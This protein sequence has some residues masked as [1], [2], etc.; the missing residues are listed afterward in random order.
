M[1]SESRPTIAVVIHP[2]IHDRTSPQLIRLTSAFAAAD[3]TYETLRATALVRRDPVILHVNWPEHVVRSDGPLV[4]RLLKQAEAI[5]IAMLLVVRPHAVVWTAHNLEPHDGWNGPIE[6]S[7]F[8]AMRRRMS[9]VITLVPGHRQAIVARYPDLE[10][11]PFEAIEWGSVA[12]TS[13][14]P[15]ARPPNGTPVRLLMVGAIGPYKQQLDVMRWLKPFIESDQATL[16][17][18]GPLG[19][20]AYLE[21]IR[22]IAP[23][24]G[25]EV[26]DRWVSDPD[27]DDI[28]RAHHAV[29]AP[30]D[31]AFNT[32]VPSVTL[33]AGT[34]IVLSPS[35]QADWLIESQG[36]AWVRLLP[37]SSDPDS[38]ENMLAW[39]A[40]ERSGPSPG[41]WGWSAQAE[42]HRRIY[43][44]ASNR[45]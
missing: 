30:Q 44:R 18:A 14:H 40:A 13:E 12:V 19:D 22:S 16:T 3:V 9:S 39:A 2:V 25:F 11:V 41:P 1:E 37:D 38:I 29:V 36:A 20:P 6:R 27:L 7:L 4:K 23:D 10:D 31:H 15:P 33:P 8:W 34:P 45:L 35:R 17:L 24:H 28:I 42:T 26:I 5:V 21:Q 43:E 32:G